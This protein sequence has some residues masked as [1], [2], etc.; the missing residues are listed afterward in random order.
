MGGAPL[1]GFIGWFFGT[2][3]LYKEVYMIKIGFADYYLDNWHANNYPAFL[4]EA[5]AK[6]GYDAQVYAAYGIK[7]PEGGIGTIDW[8]RQRNVKPMSSMAELIDSVDA[9]MVIAADNSRFH[10]MVCPEP[11]ASGKPVYVDKTFAHDLETAKKL[12]ALA[13]EHHT[14]VFSSSAQRYC[15]H[16]IDYLAERKEPA[17]FMSTVG[18]HSLA[19]YAVHQLEPIV[20]VMGCGVKRLKA[21]SAGAA[22]TQLILDYGGGRLA[23]FC[24]SP[25][26]WAEFNFMVSDGETGRRLYSDDSNF[27]LN[28]MKAILDFF[29]HGI[30]PVQK[31]ETLEIIAII[32]TAARARE[33]PDQ[34]FD[35]HY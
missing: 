19:N 8:C 16:L 29:V 11:L 25:Q 34:W 30:V 9:I 2:D 18:P 26:P 4:R 23:S 5:I 35:L 10:E 33:C 20:A 31:Q 3:S 14:P 13:D 17:R 21:F 1:L 6:Y 22:V 32:E 7:D 15:Q 28:L 24:Q 12:F 27:Y